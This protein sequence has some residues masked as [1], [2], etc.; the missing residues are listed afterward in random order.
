MLSLFKSCGICKIAIPP[1][2]I[3]GTIPAW[4]GIIWNVPKR[5]Y[6]SHRI[7]CLQRQLQISAFTSA[8]GEN[9]SVVGNLSFFACG[10]IYKS[11]FW[12]KMQDFWALKNQ[13]VR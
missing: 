5:G 12:S 2:L 4:L 7:D 1:V 9:K 6:K 11:L 13:S 3:R 10:I 8:S